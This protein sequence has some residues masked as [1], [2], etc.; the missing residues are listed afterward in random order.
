MERGSLSLQWDSEEQ[1][2]VVK[3]RYEGKPYATLG[4]VD[5]ED[6]AAEIDQ[7][8]ETMQGRRNWAKVFA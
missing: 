2:Q 7:A 1:E 4:K 6:P 8:L 3:I 5:A